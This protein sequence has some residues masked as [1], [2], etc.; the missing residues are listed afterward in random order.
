MNALLQE[1]STLFR[2]Y[3][4]MYVFHILDTYIMGREASSRFLVVG[5]VLFVLS[6]FLQA[7]NRS[8]V[9][10]YA[11]LFFLVT[12]AVL[13]YAELGKPGAHTHKQPVESPSPSL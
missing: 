3:V 9:R 8:G 10:L 5:A 1:T 13:A 2:P 12:V 6:L 4:D 11:R 7:E